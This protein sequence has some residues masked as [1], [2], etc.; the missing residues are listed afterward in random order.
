MKEMS[1][2]IHFYLI[3]YGFQ[4]EI[5]EIQLN[6]IYIINQNFLIFFIK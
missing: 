1:N 3:N 6:K 4:M 2:K 5:S